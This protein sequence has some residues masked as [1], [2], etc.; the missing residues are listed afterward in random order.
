VTRKE[1]LDEL[2]KLLGRLKAANL[3]SPALVEGDRDV[4]ALKLLGLNGEIL[5]LNQG[6]SLVQRTDELSH[7][8]RKVILLTDWDDKG[9]QLHDRLRGLLEDVQVES[10]DFFWSRLKK[11]VGGGSRT[12]EDIPAFIQILRERAGSEG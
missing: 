2:E 9:V 11:L 5:K 1:Q 12:V 10:D 8:Y 7:T 6:Q 4:A 3:E